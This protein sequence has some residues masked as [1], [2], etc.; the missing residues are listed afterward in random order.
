[1]IYKLIVKDENPINDM[2]LEFTNLEIA[3]QYRDKC[4][5]Q[6]YKSVAIEE[7]GGSDDGKQ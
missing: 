6:G 1:M 3:E 5:K 2:E 7:I 4:I